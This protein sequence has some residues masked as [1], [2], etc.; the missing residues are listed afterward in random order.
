MQEA[1]QSKRVHQP[2]HFATLNHQVN[3]ADGQQDFSIEIGVCWL[4]IGVL[5]G[6]TICYYS[7]YYGN[8]NDENNDGE[9]NAK[10][11]KNK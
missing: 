5:I 1:N 9:H 8:D 4:I 10:M 2:N 3:V 6:C 11:R 7:F